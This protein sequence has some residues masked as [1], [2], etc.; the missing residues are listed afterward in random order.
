MPTILGDSLQDDGGIDATET[1]DPASGKTTISFTLKYWIQADDITQREDDILA[2]VGL[3]GLMTFLRGAYC[4][5]RKAMES[6]AGAL[7]WD[8]SCD[9]SSD[10]SL[11]EDPLEPPN[12]RIARVSWTSEE[13]E[14]LIEFDAQNGAPI[15]NV[16]NERIVATGKALVPVLQIRR[17][18]LYP[19]DPLNFLLYANHVNT[20]PFLGAPEG[21]ALL[22]PMDAGEPQNINGVLYTDVTYR[23]AF[24]IRNIEFQVDN[25]NDPPI[26]FNP[27]VVPGLPE[28]AWQI[29][30][31]NYGTRVRDAPGGEIKQAVD[32]DGNPKEVNLDANG[33]ELAEGADPIYLPFN[34]YPGANFDDLD[35]LTNRFPQ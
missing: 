16:N 21:S 3:P 4:L 18:E 12:Q 20:D 15:V 11:V 35:L 14:E 19:F 2:T 1:Y 6:T 13:I 7:L 26:A 28:K 10:I 5:D 33:V 34:K 22:R 27:V 30:L 23:I 24:R 17:W 9:F 31:L 8:V 32:S 25:N 29:K